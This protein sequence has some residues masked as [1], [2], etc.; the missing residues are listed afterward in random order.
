MSKQYL[1]SL[2]LMISISLLITPAF[3]FDSNLIDVSIQDG[4]VTEYNDY[5]I[6][7]MVFSVFNNNTQPA[8]FSGHNMIYLNDTNS[9]WWEYSNDSDLDGLSETD[10]PQLNATINPGNSTDVKLCFLVQHDPTI[11]YSVIVNNDEKL[12]DMDIQEFVLESVPTSFKSVASAWCSDLIS[13]SEFIELSQS[14]IQNGTINVI[15]GQSVPDV[16][17]AIPSWIKS[18]SCDW[19]NE[20]ISDFEFLDGLYWLIDNGKI[21][22]D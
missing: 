22:L 9:D 11:G 13:E 4:Y 5:D 17:S 15:R 16:G 12:M 3:A 1:I 19:S 21:Q 18:S 20:L 6:I 7:T 2:L 10:C 14:N 8:Q